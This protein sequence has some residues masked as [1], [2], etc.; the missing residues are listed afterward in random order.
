MLE[1]ILTWFL[2]FLSFLRILIFLDVI[3]S[4][5]SSLFWSNIR[6]NVFASILDPLYFQVKKYLPTNIW[7]IDLTPLVILFIIMFL[8]G[9]VFILFPE[10][11]WVI[12]NYY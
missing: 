7:V 6:L 12:K 2:F 8:E 9:F 4:L 11:I 1:T 3:L 10:M 5:L